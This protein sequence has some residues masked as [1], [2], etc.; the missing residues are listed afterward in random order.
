MTALT[1]ASLLGMGLQGFGVL[2]GKATLFGAGLSVSGAATAATIWFMTGS[3]IDWSG[4]PQNPNVPRPK[5][6]IR[7]IEGAEYDAARAQANAANQALH[8]ANP[9]LKGFEIHEI[10]PVKFGGDPI[11]I[12]NKVPLT[13]S[14]HMEFT[15][16]WNNLL[17]IILPE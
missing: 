1:G 4:Y 15:K 17:N 10:K 5:G 14:E 13:P 12:G 8:R 9:S 7:I 6:P 3:K 11:G 2:F 16:W